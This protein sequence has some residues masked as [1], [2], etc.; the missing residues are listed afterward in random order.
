[1]PYF[2]FSDSDD[3]ASSS[4]PAHESQVQLATVL[5]KKN[6]SPELFAPKNISH[7][8]LENNLNDH[9][10]WLY[11]NIYSVAYPGSPPIPAHQ[12]LSRVVHGIAHVSRA[13]H[14]V[15]VLAN[16][17]RRHGASGAQELTSEDVRLLQIAALFHDSAREGEETDYWDHESALLLYCYLRNALGVEQEKARTIAE[18]TANKDIG[19]KGYFR[20][21]EEDNGD[22]TG[23][24]DTAS[25]PYQKTIY[26]Q[27]I[28][29]A[30]CLDIIRARPCFNAEYLD[31]YQL[32]A[33]NNPQA[34]EEQAQLICEARSLIN[35]VGDAWG[36]LDFSVKTHYE[37]HHCFQ[38]L[39]QEIE[40]GAY[41]VLGKLGE[42]LHPIEQLTQM[43]L[44]NTTAFTPDAELTQENLESA[45]REGRILG[46]SII[47]P[48]EELAIGAQKGIRRNKAQIEFQKML[49][50]PGIPTPSS[51]EDRY[52]KQGNPDRSFSLMGYGAGLWSNAGF[53]VINPDLGDVKLISDTDMDSSYAKKTEMKKLDN[54][55]IEQIQE[56]YSALH[57]KIKMGGTFKNRG[58]AGIYMTHSEILYR[59][60]R[61]DAIYFSKDP[62]VQNPRITAQAAFLQAV[63]LRNEYE[64]IYETTRREYIEVHGESAGELLFKKD[65]G[66]KKQL[67][68]IEYSYLHNQIKPVPA[69]DLTDD[70]LVEQWSQMVEHYIK[71]QLDTGNIDVLTQSNDIIK[72]RSMYRIETYAANE[73]RSDLV[74]RDYLLYNSHVHGAGVRP[75]DSNYPPALQ[76]RISE[77]IEQQKANMARAYEDSLYERLM[78]GDGSILSEHSYQL[79]MLSPGFRE[80]LKA[81]GDK[82]NVL[83]LTIPEADPLKNQAF[84]YRPLAGEEKEIPKNAEHSFNLFYGSHEIPDLRISIDKQIRLIFA[85]GL[86]VRECLGKRLSEEENFGF[87]DV[88]RLV[89]GSSCYLIK[90]DQVPSLDELK[91]A[92]ASHYYMSG[93]NNLYYYDKLNHR[94]HAFQLTPADLND[95]KEDFPNPAGEKI[96]LDG[97]K[98]HLLTATASAD[99]GIGQ[100]Q[101]DT[102]LFSTMVNKLKSHY[103][104]NSASFG[105]NYRVSCNELNRCVFELVRL[106]PDST[107]SEAE[108]ACLEELYS[109]IH[110]EHIRLMAGCNTSYEP[111]NPLF[112]AVLA[113]YRNKIQQGQHLR[114]QPAI[115]SSSSSESSIQDSPARHI[116]NPQ[117]SARIP[118]GVIGPGPQLYSDDAAFERDFG[119]P[120]R[121]A[122]SNNDTQGIRKLLKKRINPD[123]IS[124][125]DYQFRTSFTALNYAI[126]HNQSD[127]VTLLL[128]AGANPNQFQMD[129]SP[130]CR[131]IDKKNMSMIQ[132]LLRHGANPDMPSRSLVMESFTTMYPLN[133]AVATDN[134]DLANQLL[135]AGALPDP[136]S[137]PL[138]TAVFNSMLDMV[139]TLLEHGIEVDDKCNDMLALLDDPSQVPYFPPVDEQG[140]IKE[141]H[142]TPVKLLKFYIA[143][144]LVSAAIDKQ[145]DEI[146]TMCQSLSLNDSDDWHDQFRWL[147][148][149]PGQNQN[150][151]NSPAIKDFCNRLLGFL[152]KTAVDDRNYSFVLAE[153]QKRHQISLQSREELKN[154]L[155]ILLATISSNA[156]GDKDQ[157]VMDYCAEKREAM[158]G[159]QQ[160][161]GYLLII[162]AELTETLRSL[163]SNEVRLVKEAIQNLR[164]DGL[165]FFGKTAKAGKIEAA[166]R[167]TPLSERGRVLS[168]ERPG[169]EAKSVQKELA[170]HRFLLAGKVYK[171]ANGAIDEQKAARSYRKLKQSLRDIAEVPDKTGDDSAT[172]GSSN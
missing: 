58:F 132:A 80:R 78:S 156:I 130:L 47:Y 148:A 86:N 10:N 21:Y 12:G 60:T 75:A 61:V 83:F 133:I 135:N 72:I 122:L 94:L 110:S 22:I 147:I 71:T 5:G 117:P 158:A 95:L 88:I 32:I 136:E 171:T 112:T 149:Y 161:V 14:Y 134:V 59:F 15:P 87:D 146:R 24:F 17:Y 30:D 103:F 111:D 76:E 164:Q 93:D 123:D 2:N 142:F 99:V 129:V 4:A 74:E 170:R 138:H 57:R 105:L 65:V 102:W 155:D 143:S 115:P 150:N 159:N 3:A 167:N 23:D 165:R 126:E 34:F 144:A 140:I 97:F 101:I 131:A 109:G 169:R 153:Y 45:L 35:R 90:T 37:G 9:A 42:S 166:L 81:G 151:N 128:E 119:I 20:I 92:E 66:E 54:P 13:A 49:R 172:P 36:R 118:G 160:N 38:K 51:K 152:S 154:E 73:Q 52:S 68:I 79:I 168:H 41:P 124:I 89:Y 162:R 120:F 48:S 125:F 46:R 43:T 145:P 7:L 106:L 77:V 127:M 141:E 67:P 6:L 31:F 107:L 116:P 104:N 69:T 163:Q 139:K 137:F 85:L 16:L 1:M 121:E 29:D 113:F 157:K 53:L 82:L 98:I 55:S 26:H 44:V 63:F 56:Q 33:I 19:H 28:H 27:I 96:Y 25:V 91:D 64:K 100:V 84:V 50:R 39:R 114:Q 70:F 8:S 18:A 11:Q 108:L 62:T 40:S